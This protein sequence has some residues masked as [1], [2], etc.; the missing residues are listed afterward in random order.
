MLV[1]Q[2]QIDL[3][4]ALKAGDS[5]AVSTLRMALAALRNRQIELKKLE[6]NLI[7]ED[8]EVLAAL[9]REAKKRREAA[10]LYRTGLRVELAER[11][12]A[13]LKI[14]Q[15]Y[16]PAELS[17]SELSAVVSEEAVRVGREF[18]PLMKAV[19]AR[20]KGRADGKAVQE[21]IRALGV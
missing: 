4:T 12:E 16:L 5:A 15:K 21:K 3:K 9:E 2:I 7:L 19:M 6:E 8:E 10:S 13:E 18:A 1:D 11:E 20:V 17:D 14:L